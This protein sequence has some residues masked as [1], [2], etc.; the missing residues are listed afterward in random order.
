MAKIK[1][2]ADEIILWIR[3][4]GKANDIPNGEITGLGRRIHDL[5]VTELKGEKIRDDESSYWANS[6]EDKHI[7]KFELPKT[8][9]QYE[10][11]KLRPLLN[12]V[13]TPLLQRVSKLT[14]LV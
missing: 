7:D 8:S 4:N 11:V 6:T 1:I 5:I 14:R 3:K 12:T 13:P 10:I 2:G 9:A